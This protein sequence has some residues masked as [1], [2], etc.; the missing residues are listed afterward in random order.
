MN[1]LNKVAEAKQLVDKVRAAVGDEAITQAAAYVT[2]ARRSSESS[3]GA[4]T[5]ISV[6]A[7]EAV[8]TTLHAAAKDNDLKSAVRLVASGANVNETDE[9]GNAPLHYAVKAGATRIVQLLLA[10]GADPTLKNSAGVSPYQIR[11]TVEIANFFKVLLQSPSES[12]PRGPLTQVSQAQA[13]AYIS[14]KEPT[15]RRRC[16]RLLSLDGGGIRGLVL[17]EIERLL[18]KGPLIQHF[19]WIAGTST[20]AILALALSKGHSLHECLRLYLQLKD[21]V[22]QGSRPYDAAFIEGFLKEKFGADTRMTEIKGARVLI[23]ATKADVNPPELVVFRNYS[24]AGGR[25]VNVEKKAIDPRTVPIWKAARCSSAAPT[26][27]PSV[28]GMLM[29][30]GLIANNPSLELLNEVH[31]YNT[32]K[33]LI[34]QKPH[35]VREIGCMVSVGTGRIPPERLRDIDITMPNSFT[36]FV[37]NITA[38]KG[39]MN[40]LTEQLACSDGQVVERAQAFAH[41][42]NAPFFR[43]TPQLNFDVPLDTKDDDI[44]VRLLWLTKVYVTVTCR[45]DI[46]TLVEL[47]R[48]EERFY[49]DKSRR[50]CFSF[51][52]SG[53]GGKCIR[54]CAERYS[55]LFQGILTTSRANRAATDA[56]LVSVFRLIYG[57]NHFAV[58]V[59]MCDVFPGNNT[60]QGKTKKEFDADTAC[61]KGHLGEEQ[62]CPQG[63]QCKYYWPGFYNCVNSTI[64]EMQK[65]GFSD[66]CPDGSTA[67]GTFGKTC[68][69]MFC[70]AEE[71]CQQINPYFA[72]CCKNN[73]LK[74]EV[75]HPK[76]TI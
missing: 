17:M 58:D 9:A 63:Y 23:T 25:D 75:K 57:C 29:D 43:F 35:E 54:L 3:G 36:S 7:I 30:G 72:K 37:S 28:D 56:C 13:L 45:E 26:Y 55:P 39:L 71:N 22:F 53:S 24:L 34:E 46:Q 31:Y 44:L 61:G 51:K 50:C 11:S 14:G 48:L 18:D 38:I 12:L 15:E 60:V 76:P 47:L 73:Q 4:S 66:K 74:T 10:I 59:G 40:V 6:A 19:D 70:G 49:Y 8:S 64:A 67:R 16:L 68:D 2:S 33:Q 41:A 5:R 62:Y 32:A 1:W 21:D 65:A 27:F 42:Q 69:E 20:G 52:Y